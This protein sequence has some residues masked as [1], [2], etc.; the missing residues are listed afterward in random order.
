MFFYKVFKRR[1]IFNYSLKFVIYTNIEFTIIKYKS[2]YTRIEN[3][4]ISTKCL[5]IIKN[6]K[7]TPKHYH[8]FG[9]YLQYKC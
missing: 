9:I 7:A 4:L 5:N 3:L 8:Y 1:F 6:F 2:F